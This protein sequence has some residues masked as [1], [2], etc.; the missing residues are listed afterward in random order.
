MAINPVGPYTLQFPYFV[1]SLQHDLEINCDVIGTPTPG[2]IA[3]SVLMRSKGSTTPTL[4]DSADAIWELVRPFFNTATLCSTFALYKRNPDTTERQFIS[5]GD[6]ST[7]NGSNATAP[8]LASQLTLAWR[9]V[10]GDGLKLVLLE[11]VTGGNN[12]RAPMTSLGDPVIN[13]INAYMLSDDSVIAGRDRS[14]AV[15]PIN[16]SFG[17]NEKVWARRYRS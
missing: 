15:S 6:L 12:T 5:G 3:T 13:A 2:T 4:Q 17:Q 1:P 9:T 7:P 16:A 14:F 8:N 10:N 11:L